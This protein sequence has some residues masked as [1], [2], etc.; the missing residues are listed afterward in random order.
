[1]I[2]PRS[3]GSNSALSCAVFVCRR[4]CAVAADHHSSALQARHGIYSVEL[5]RNQL[6][7]LKFLG[8]ESGIGDIMRTKQ[9]AER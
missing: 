6:V 5:M 7:L 8:R 3:Y 2:P 1:M 4:S 9:V